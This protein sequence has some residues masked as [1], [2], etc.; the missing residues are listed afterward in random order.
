M[1]DLYLVPQVRNAKRHGA[2]IS[3]CSRVLGIYAACMDLPEV[4]AT[5]PEVV[6]NRG[7]AARG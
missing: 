1:A 6:R 3:A 4:R 5:D 7:S 2:N